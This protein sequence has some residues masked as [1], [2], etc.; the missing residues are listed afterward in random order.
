MLTKIYLL[1]VYYNSVISSQTS[2]WLEGDKFKKHNRQLQLNYN[3]ISVHGIFSSYSTLFRS[4]LIHALSGSKTFNSSLMF[5]YLGLD[6]IAS[7]KTS[8]LYQVINSSS[9]KLIIQFLLFF[10][11]LWQIL[12]TN[13]F[14]IL[15]Q[16]IP[17][18]YILAIKLKVVHLAY[19][20]LALFCSQ[21]L[22]RRHFAYELN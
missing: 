5:S 20:T 13:N 6:E 4:T 16:N 10:K 8:I 15:I 3:T 7:D 22:I 21:I 9:M 1:F 19:I 2:R 18:L 17:I 11:S 12:L 14:K